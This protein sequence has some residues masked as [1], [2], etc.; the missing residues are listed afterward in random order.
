LGDQIDETW[1]QGAVFQPT[2]IGKAL[3]DFNLEEQDVLII[4]SQ[5]CDVVNDSF[6]SEPFVEVQVAKSIINIDGNHSHGKHP[7]ILDIRCTLDDVPRCFR[8]YDR[9]RRRFNR[10]LLLGR[11]PSAVLPVDTVRLLANWTAR[12]YT[13][14]AL[15]DEFNRRRKSREKAAAKIATEYAEDVSAFYVVLNEDR[16][17]SVDEPYEIFLIGTALAEIAADSG[18]FERISKAV[19]A[20]SDVLNA[21]G[22]VVVGGVARSE[23]SVSLTEVREMIRLD[24]D[25]ISL[26][27]EGNDCDP[28]EL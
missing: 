4:V 11:L 27:E 9:E 7:R 18:R 21:N 22:I 6:D 5:S 10:R 15:P 20:L 19:A 16:E 14:P 13:R 23:D 2:A 3:A 1:Q 26:R 12:R 24:F 25:Y 17:L 8:I 28:I